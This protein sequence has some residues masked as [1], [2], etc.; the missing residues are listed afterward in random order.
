M[1]IELLLVTGPTPFQ[2]YS[3][4]S[5]MNYQCPLTLIASYPT[6]VVTV[7]RRSLPSGICT[8]QRCSDSGR[9]LVLS[10]PKY[11]QALYF[12]KDSMADFQTL[13]IS[14]I[15]GVWLY[16]LDALLSK[17]QALMV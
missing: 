12:L 15:Y 3:V 16:Y 5:R 9:V 2:A 7:K 14:A 6:A 17:K 4:E 11:N 1:E 8:I 13:R 10:T